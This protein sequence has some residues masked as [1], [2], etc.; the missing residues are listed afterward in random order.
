MKMKTLGEVLIIVGALR[1]FFGYADSS[2]VR[3]TW[4]A[5]E[6]MGAIVSGVIFVS[7]AKIV[8]AIT[9]STKE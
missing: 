5:V 6:A 7:T 9:K 2:A 4:Y 1:L 8:E 3:M